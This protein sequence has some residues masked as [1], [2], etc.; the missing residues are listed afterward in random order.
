VLF[1]LNARNVQIRP[2]ATYVG[3]QTDRLVDASDERLIHGDFTITK[4]TPGDNYTVVEAEQ[5]D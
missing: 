2:A 3:Q 1:K 4:V 5:D